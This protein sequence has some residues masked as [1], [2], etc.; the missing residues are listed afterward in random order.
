MG[1]YGV[2]SR[3][4]TFPAVGKPQTGKLL[5]TPPPA[6]EAPPA[7]Q[8]L[9]GAPPPPPVGVSG[10]PSI[11]PAVGPGAPPPGT[12]LPGGPPPGPSA[13][14]PP[15]TGHAPQTRPGTPPPA[16]TPPPADATWFMQN[17]DSR[18]S[19]AQ[20]DAWI[21]MGLLDPSA[22]GGA[23]FRTE[24]V[25]ENGQPIPGLFEKPTDCPEGMTKFGAQQCLPLG[26]PKLAGGGAGLPPGGGGPGTAGRGM[27]EEERRYLSTI[28]DLARM[29]QG[30]GEQLFQVGM[31]AYQQATDYFQKILGLKGRAGV[32]E[33]IA[34]AA[35]E[36]AGAYRGARSQVVM[37]GARGAAKDIALADLARAEAGDIN[38][39]ASSQTGSAA[40][41]LLASSQFGVASGMQGEV[42]AAGVNQAVQGALT[43]NRQ[44]EE[45]LSQQWD[46]A[47]LSARTTKEVAAMQADASYASI[48]AQRDI[49]QQQLAA[50]ASEFDRTF[51][52]QLQQ[53][54]EQ[55]RQFTLSQKTAAHGANVGAIGAGLGA[56]GGIAIVLI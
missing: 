26:H 36:T 6:A 35:E 24:N 20:W 41:G 10:P 32:Q 50:R 30:Q 48:A 9:A 4:R 29:L 7:A 56:A 52:L 46:I 23:R 14:P 39:I 54:Q 12:T 22:T 28:T 8:A 19:A 43:Q 17:V 40:Q 18:V 51:Q 3:Q 31:P 38:S 49:A 25:D 42:Q 55:M 33:A 13:G 45:G 27:T 44:F 37:S 5:S 53:F 15:G 34:P 11:P 47:A 2:M 1:T 21:Q 16:T